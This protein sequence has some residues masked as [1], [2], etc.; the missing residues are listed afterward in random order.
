MF[1]AARRKT[2]IESLGDVFGTREARSRK[3]PIGVHYS[4]FWRARETKHD[5]YVCTILTEYI[6]IE[7]RAGKTDIAILLKFLSS[8]RRTDISRNEQRFQFWIERREEKNRNQSMMQL[9]T[10]LNTQKNQIFERLM[11]FRWSILILTRERAEKPDMM[12]PPQSFEQPEKN[13]HADAPMWF[14]FWT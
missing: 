14:W 1:W 10:S 7:P 3:K 9:T 11:L 8:Q 4:E 5:R 2:D 12:N 6:D 13:R